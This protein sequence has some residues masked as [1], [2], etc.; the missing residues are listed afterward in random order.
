MVSFLYSSN[1]FILFGNLLSSIS[2]IN[3][4]YL[5][6]LSTKSSSFID[7]GSIKI[8]SLILLMFLLILLNFS[9][10]TSISF[11]IAVAL[12]KRFLSLPYFFIK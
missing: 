11:F 5:I 1:N 12:S 7:S 4:L 8:F 6:I 10:R 9:S 2:E 3:S